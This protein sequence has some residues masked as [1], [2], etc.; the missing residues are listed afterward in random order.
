VSWTRS[1]LLILLACAT[2]ARAEF[3]KI[4]NTEPQEAKHPLT[5]PQKALGMMSIPTGFHASVFAAEPDVQQPIAIALDARG[6]LW[7]AENYTYSE[8]KV[9]FSDQL[10]DRIVILE[11]TDGDGKFDKRT[12]FWDAFQKLT[13]VEVG[14]GG[15]W[16]TCAPRL[17][18]IPD[19]NGDDIPD[20]EPIVVLDGFNDTVIRHNIVNGLRWG[21][22]GWLYGRHGIQASSSVGKPGAPPDQRVTFNAAIWRYHPVTQ[23][24]EVVAQGTTNPWGYDWNDRGELFFINTVI[25]HLW[26]VLPGAHYQRM[27]GEDLNPCVYQ[28]L[29]Q[30][31]DHYHWDTGK[32]WQDSRDVRGLTDKLGGGHAHVGCMIYLGDNWPDN[33]R[34]TLFTFNFH[35]K[36]L[37]NDL[38][39]RQGAGY[40][41]KHGEDFWRTTDPW[42]R[43]MDLLYGPDG[44]VFMADWT[45][46]GDCHENDGVHRTSGRIYKMWYGD[47]R[48]PAV[49]DLSKLDDLELV[50]LQLHKNDWYVRQ[51]RRLLA[52]RAAAGKDMRPVHASLRE[53]FD[54]QADVTRKLRAL[55]CLYVTGGTDEPSLR[56]LLANAS[57]ESLRA[58]A[59]RLMVDRGAP[60]VEAVTAMADAAAKDASGLVQLY[61]AS[62]MQRLPLDQ[63]WQIGEKLAAGPEFAADPWLPLMIWYGIEP[64]VPAD[65]AKAIATAEKTPMGVVRK[66]IARRLTGNLE[67]DPAAVD[68]LV[69]TLQS[70][71]AQ[72]QQDVLDGMAAALRGWRKA[73]PPPSWTAVS[74]ALANSP[75]DRV[76]RLTAEVGTVFGDGRA[77]DELRRLASAKREDLAVREQAVQSLVESRADGVLPLLQ[78]LLNDKDLAPAV[79]RGLA[80]YND[81]STP[82]IILQG[83]KKYN[84][85]GKQAALATLT[86]RPP[87]AKA[88]L[89]AVAAGV[90]PRK[91]VAAYQVRQMRN[92]G[93]DQIGQKLDELWPEL[94]GVSAEKR[95]ILA[96]Y[97]AMLTD[98]R[99]ASADAPSG[100]KLFSQTCAQCHT[101]YGEG[102]K[103][104][105]DLTGSDRHSIDYLLDNI[106]DP[107]AVVADVYRVSL[108]KLKDGRI[109]D[110]IVVE[111]TDRT[112]TLQTPQER[113]VLPKAD[114]TQV[115]PSK[116]SMMPEGLLD[117]LKPEQVR[118]LIG[119]LMS[120][121]QVDLPGE[122]K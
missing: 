83:Y 47:T 98:G 34:D 75:S 121:Q 116:L 71:S 74:A 62:A 24:F 66:Y 87:Y 12:V 95:P 97:K 65:P 72:Y 27:Y 37:N 7:V 57:D 112:L 51:A 82:K 101:L 25:G 104:G 91:E 5:A 59:V 6:R 16:A 11:D 45:D 103:I 96:K 76:K 93:D 73:P 109:L 80:A 86:S 43:G 122:A 79:I 29:P 113:L 63:R 60:S 118:D 28:L 119:Y 32:T 114:V 41:G 99:L 61:L 39:L 20:S 50:N 115:K 21:P 69:A 23:K 3:P 53:M 13:S 90:V 92:L 31:A 55:W 4:F 18:F 8:Q 1:A 77:V 17:L 120:N 106:I 107:S 81:P 19:R 84:P 35:G 22:D 15:V 52:E 30:T 33:Y 117:T 111:Q 38:L 10:R 94:K 58:W 110:G 9:N 2:R 85:Q 108:V 89:D 68:R 67:K 49:K 88:L 105:P 46:I 48:P 54:Q 42:F 70:A 36:R 100:R 102:G 56:K 26:H 40:V 78:Q 14:F 44:G 64:A